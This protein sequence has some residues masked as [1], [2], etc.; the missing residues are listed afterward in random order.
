M[1]I[2][3]ATWPRSIPFKKYVFLKTGG[4]GSKSSME[5]PAS[6]ELQGAWKQPEGRVSPAG[7]VHGRGSE[8]GRHD[9][10]RYI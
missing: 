9:G 5:E 4:R 8:K 2:T 10:D 3:R 7:S 6:E 1:R